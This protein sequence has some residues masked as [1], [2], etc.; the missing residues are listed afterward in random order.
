MQPLTPRQQLRRERIEGLI[1]LAA[2]VLDLVLVTGEGVSRVFG[3]EDEYIPIR[4]PADALDLERA[5][6]AR[7]R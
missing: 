1:A 6:S 4:A 2:P 7:P 3:R 5:R